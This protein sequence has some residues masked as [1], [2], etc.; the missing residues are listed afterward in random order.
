MF[1]RSRMTENVVTIG[2]KRSLYEALI[3]FEKN[4]Y[5][6]LPVLDK[7]VLRG[8][9]TEKNI[10][11]EFCAFCAKQNISA[12]VDIDLPLPFSTS[13][14]E[15]DVNKRRIAQFLHYRTVEELM[16][17]D[18]QSIDKET[19][20]EEAADI[21]LKKDITILPVVNE[22]GELRGV[23]TKSDILAVFDEIFAVGEKGERITVAVDDV[24]GSLG[25]I[26][27]TLRNAKINI[28]SVVTTIPRYRDVSLV[29]LKVEQGEKAREVLENNH[30]KVLSS[31]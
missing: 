16:E 27:G 1:V 3:L 13:K 7:G 12:G 20:I 26:T 2:P 14:L 10:M 23:I 15:L 6:G 11:R 24:V 31:I 30:F 22:I 8:I 28:L 9:I 25:K 17:T 18:I 29:T 19:P 5:E 4:Q 21:M